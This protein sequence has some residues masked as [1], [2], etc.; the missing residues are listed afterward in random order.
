MSTA[1]F[2]VGCAFYTFSILRLLLS[3]RATPL[4]LLGSRRYLVSALFRIPLPITAWSASASKHPMPQPCEQRRW[5]KI[6]AED[7]VCLLS[8]DSIYCVECS[9]VQQKAIRQ[10][11]PSPI[12]F[13]SL[14][15]DC[16]VSQQGML[17][18]QGDSHWWKP[19]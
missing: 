17:S 11:W 9:L 8:L 3:E 5:H 16:A 14:S 15:Y 7:C 18:L 1:S 12:F 4:A 2:C 13:V 6:C 10:G 19:F